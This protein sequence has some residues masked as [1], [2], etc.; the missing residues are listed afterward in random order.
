MIVC[1]FKGPRVGF[2]TTIN[3][4][5]FNLLPMPLYDEF[6][7][8]DEDRQDDTEGNDQERAAGAQAFGRTT[9]AR[10]Q[11]RRSSWPGASTP[12]LQERCRDRW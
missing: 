3:L 8:Q 1:E 9:P 11:E 12:G 6:A 7:Q 5:N 4:A 10:L 2:R